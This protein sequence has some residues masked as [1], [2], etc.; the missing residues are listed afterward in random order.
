[1]KI[2]KFTFSESSQIYAIQYMKNQNDS[3]R[4]NDRALSTN[5]RTCIEM[6]SWVHQIRF[7]YDFKPELTRDEWLWSISRSKLHSRNCTE[8]LCLSNQVR[9]QSILCHANA[10][11]KTRPKNTSP[12][13]IFAQ[14]NSIADFGLRFNTGP[15]IF[16]YCNI[17]SRIRINFRE[18][19]DVILPEAIKRECIHCYNVQRSQNRH[20]PHYTVI[21]GHCKLGWY[22]FVW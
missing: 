16:V 17:M 15:D 5:V 10:K 13:P 9:F 19:V 21:Y 8:C 6:H 2:S 18:F 11:T 3:I 4:R 20:D 7:R 12:Y 1:M 22:H 14:L